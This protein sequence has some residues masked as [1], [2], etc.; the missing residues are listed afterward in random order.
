MRRSIAYLSAQACSR[1]GF[2]S[3]AATSAKRS[4][5]WSSPPATCQSATQPQPT[6]ATLR[7]LIAR[8]SGSDASAEATAKAPSRKRLHLHDK[9]SPSME[10][11]RSPAPSRE[12]GGP[13]LDECGQAFE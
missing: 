10:N 11:G 13:L 8:L 7:R 2:E 3:H 1:S 6:N 5:Q 9:K 12:P 4:G